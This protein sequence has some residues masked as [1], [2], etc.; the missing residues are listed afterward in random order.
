MHRF[1]KVFIFLIVFIGINV[2]AGPGQKVDCNGLH[3]GQFMCPDPSRDQ[4][5]PKT[6]QFYGCTKENSAKGN[7]FI[8]KV[9]NLLKISWFYIY[10]SIK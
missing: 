7:F 1:C 4:I 8:Y 9:E 3:M 10:E 5:D 2:D 6:Q